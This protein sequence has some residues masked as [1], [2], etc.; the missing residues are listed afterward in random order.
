MHIS[1]STIDMKNIKLSV[2]SIFT[3]ADCL[4]AA[5]ILA[6]ILHDP[7]AKKDHSRIVRIVTVS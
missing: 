2:L 6:Y 1:V 3:G 7:R 5:I 4:L